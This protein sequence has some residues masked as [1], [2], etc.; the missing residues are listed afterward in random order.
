MR[1]TPGQRP[2]AEWAAVRS[3]QWRA[4]AESRGRT[5]TGQL[6]QDCWC[7]PDRSVNRVQPFEHWSVGARHHNR[8]DAV[9]VRVLPIFFVGGKLLNE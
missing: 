2:R 9:S 1:A 7:D 3:R 4:V 8:A 5:V 6:T